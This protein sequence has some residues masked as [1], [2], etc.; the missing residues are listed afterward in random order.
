M[1]LLTHG[2]PRISLEL[3]FDVQ[4]FIVEMLHRTQWHGWVPGRCMKCAKVAN[5]SL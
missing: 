3:V 2:L 5:D 1:T 4:E